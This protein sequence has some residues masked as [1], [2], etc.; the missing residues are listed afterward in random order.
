MSNERALVARVGRGKDCMGP[1]GFLEHGLLP[2]LR[3]I[4]AGV[5]GGKKKYDLLMGASPLRFDVSKG[6]WVW[7]GP[8]APALA[9]VGVAEPQ[10]DD[11]TN[12]AQRELASLATHFLSDEWVDGRLQW[13]DRLLL[14][15]TE[16]PIDMD[17]ILGFD[18]GTIFSL[19]QTTPGS[20]QPNPWTM[21]SK[22]EM[23]DMYEYDIAPADLTIAEIAKRWDSSSPTLASELVR[24]G[25]PRLNAM[26]EAPSGS[27]TL[28]VGCLMRCSEWILQGCQG[29]R[30]HPWGVGGCDARKK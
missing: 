8:R 30:G 23:Q 25:Q 9:P 27:N 1:G 14:V 13:L 16:T 19:A 11:D 3:Q 18:G 10:D 4:L 12:R 20:A 21:D 22:V 6:G 28:W 5:D 15:V 7:Q 17:W 29:V 26:Q 2:Y 24:C